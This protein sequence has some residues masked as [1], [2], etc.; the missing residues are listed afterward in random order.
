[1]ALRHRSGD[2]TA[3]RILSRNTGPASSSRSRADRDCRVRAR[4]LLP[5][6]RVTRL[7]ELVRLPVHDFGTGLFH[8]GTYDASYSHVYSAALVAALIWLAVRSRSIVSRPL[9]FFP[10]VALAAGLFLV[11]TTN[12]LL[13]GFWVLAVWC[14][15]ERARQI[16]RLGIRA[17]A[18]ATIGFPIGIGLTLVL[19]YEM[20]GTLTLHTYPGEGFVWDDPKMLLVMIDEQ[21]GVFRSY[22]ILGV[23]VLAGLMARRAPALSRRAG[24]RARRVYRRF[25]ATGGRGTWSSGFGHRGFVEVVPLAIPVLALALSSLPRCCRKGRRGPGRRRMTY[26]VVQMWQYWHNR[27]FAPLPELFSAVFP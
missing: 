15:P 8:Y 18:A 13:V 5:A 9:P 7:G 23:T 24:S 16:R 25:T 14:G 10:V 20:F 22:P 27:P 17:L 26:T 21:Y 11:R 19:N 6:R 12:I 2:E 3:R 1:M 4:F